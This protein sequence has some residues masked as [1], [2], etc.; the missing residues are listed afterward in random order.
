MASR[1]PS[2][3]AVTA[4]LR[5]LATNPYVGGG[6]LVLLVA[7]LALYFVVDTVLMPTYTRHDASATVPAV[8]D[9]PYEDAERLL[10]RA[11]LVV[12]RQVQPFNP[13]LP[14]D[15]VVDQNP[16]P[17]ALVKPG[18]RV[19][20][21]VN[22]GQTAK[23]TLPSVLNLPTRE[24]INR[25]RALG[26]DVA[27]VRVDPVPSPYENT[28]TQQRPEAG[29]SLEVGGEVTLWR[30]AGLGDTYVS[31]PD[32]LGLP[33]GE[34]EAR[35][36]RDE[37]RSVVIDRPEQEEGDS[38]FVITQSQ[39]PGTR[40]RAGFEVRLSVSTERPV[41]EE[42]DAEEVDTDEAIE[43]GEETEELSSR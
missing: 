25:L 16:G 41:Q 38:L 10:Q 19:Y 1:I 39:D 36:L 15:V 43:G 4:S 34:A 23:V 26:L 30:S 40:V 35:L 20:L 31:V 22:T 9:L 33:I 7:G 18:R 29:D 5:R 32:V 8:L 24:A 42:P 3:S 2:W 11:G 12:E 13:Q 27:E 37:L 14:R 17:N 28:I 21:T 6:L